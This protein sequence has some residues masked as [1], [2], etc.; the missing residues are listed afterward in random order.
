MALECL[1]FNLSLYFFIYFESNTL[2]NVVCV[3]SYEGETKIC[4]KQNAYFGCDLVIFSVLHDCHNAIQFAI[5]FYFNL[6]YRGISS[7]P[8]QYFPLFVILDLEICY[9]GAVS[10]LENEKYT[11]SKQ[12]SE[13]TTAFSMDEKCI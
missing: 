4:Y 12:F 11:S 2:H 1:Q 7:I 13:F 5:F 10:C 3:C 6:K 8:L 9:I